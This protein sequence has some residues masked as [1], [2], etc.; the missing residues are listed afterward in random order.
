MAREQ[1]TTIK[2]KKGELNS[3]EEKGGDSDIEEGETEHT[4]KEGEAE[5]AR[6]GPYILL[7]ESACHLVPPVKSVAIKYETQAG[8]SG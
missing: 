6:E 2:K 1:M 8:Y 5:G 7:K 4:G 3:G